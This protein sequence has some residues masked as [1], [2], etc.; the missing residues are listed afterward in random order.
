VFSILRHV[1]DEIIFDFKQTLI[2][3]ASV[4]QVKCRG[5]CCQEKKKTVI[6]EKVFSK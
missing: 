4:H 1:A 2:E 3:Y 5:K 6:A